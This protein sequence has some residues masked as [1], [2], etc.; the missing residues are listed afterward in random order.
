M[1][2]L[3]AA[4]VK[5]LLIV[6]FTC[7]YTVMSLIGWFKMRNK[8]SREIDLTTEPSC[9]SDPTLGK[10]GTIRLAKRDVEIHFVAKGDRSKPL[11]LFLHGFPEF[12]Y[13]LHTVIFFKGS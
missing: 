6:V 7:M 8:P 1:K 2:E 13:V 12:W 5:Y 10:H 11:M 4:I 3:F 9:L